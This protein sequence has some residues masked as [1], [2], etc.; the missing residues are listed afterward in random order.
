M[1]IAKI[2]LLIWSSVKRSLI[3]LGGGDRKQKV[4]DFAW[5]LLLHDPSL[6]SFCACWEGRK[7]SHF[8][9]FFLISIPI[10]GYSFC[11]SWV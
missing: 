7:F 1:K 2:Y 8:F 3:I 4:F 9:S 11:P 6:F 5:L 10:T